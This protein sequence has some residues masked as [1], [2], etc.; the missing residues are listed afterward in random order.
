[1]TYRPAFVNVLHLRN[2]ASNIGVYKRLVIFPVLPGVEATLTGASSGS[3]EVLIQAFSSDALGCIAL[4]A[5]VWQ[6]NLAAKVDSA[7]DITKIKIYVYSR[8]QAGA[9]TALFN[10]LT[11]EINNTTVALITT[12]SAVQTAFTVA[13]TDRLI[14]KLYALSDSG[15]SKTVT[16]YMQGVTNYSTV[17]LPNDIPVPIG[18][19][20]KAIYDTDGDG[21]F[22]LDVLDVQAANTV[23]AGRVD[24]GAALVPTFRGL[25]ALD[26]PALPY[27][28]NTVADANSILYAV[29][30]DVPAAL[31]LAANTFPARSSAG[32]ILAK[33]ITD[34]ALTIL[35]DADA[36]TA[37]ATLGVGV[38]GDISGTGVAGQVAEFVT[39]TKTIQAA[40]IIGPVSNILTITN[41]AASTLALA[42][43]SGKT[44]TLTATDNFNLTVG[45]TLTLNA[46]PIGGLSV[47]TAANTIGSLAVGLTTQILV[48]GGAATVPAWGTDL[49]TAVTIGSAYVYRAAGTDIPV[50]DGG[51]GASALA[52]GGLVIGNA[53]G[54]VSVVAAGLTTQ[55][56][57]G[58]G[59][60]T[61]PAW[62][63]DLPTA[64]T[65]GGGYVF[66]A[67]GT[68]VGVADGGTGASTLADGGLVIGNGA[69][70][71]SVVAAG[72]TTQIL[73]GGGALTD[74]AWG[75]DL[76]TA[77]T[78]GT[79]YVFRVGGTDVGVADGG[80]GVSTL[81]DGGLM[82]GNAA[83]AVSVV[84]AGLTTQILVGG[85]A[86]TDPA[87]GTDL[88]TAVTIGS[89]YI[90][91]VG[92][93]DVN[94]P[95]GGTGVSTLALNGILFGNDASAVG[96]TAIG[97]QYNILTVGA[98]P[99][100]PAWSGYLLDGTTGGKTN[101][102]VTSGKTLT[103]TAV[104]NA[105]LTVSEDVTIDAPAGVGQIQLGAAVHKTISIST[106]AMIISSTAGAITTLFT[107]DHTAKTMAI[108]TKMIKWGITDTKTLT[109]TATDDF[110][111]TIPATGTAALG[112]GTATRLAVWSTANTLAAGTI[113]QPV[114][115]VLTVTNSAA[116]TLALAITSAK[117]LTLTSTDNF[118]LTIP[119]TGT[120]LL[121]EDG[122]WVPA[123]QTWTYA[124]STT[125]T[126]ATNVTATYPA[127]TKLKLTNNSVKYFYVLSATY[128]APN[129]TVTVTGGSDYTVADAAITLPFYSYATTPQG[130]PNVFNFTPVWTGSGTNPVINNGTLSGQFIMIGRQVTYAILI[131]MG[132]TTTYGTG[133]WSFTLP[134]AANVSV[135]LYSGTAKLL[136][137]STAHYG[138]IAHISTANQLQLF[139]AASGGGAMSATV[140][141]TWAV[142]DQLRS[143]ITYFA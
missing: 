35:D 143:T 40:K 7:T 13:V 18:D 60:L 101:L 130:F 25:V 38:G 11:A 133:E 10:V 23:L 108:G 32:N 123:G 112:T 79:A 94:V 9:E 78:I 105:N 72:L 39:D 44:L 90:Y 66:R 92:G 58:G 125:F 65:I 30:N 136:D 89:G 12:L 31:A 86:L 64:V 110:N 47:A 51:T 14:I 57:V 76:P 109:L 70:A 142:N 119:A 91:R 128:G 97:A 6:F 46:Q 132:S 88:P 96:V 50:T 26:I 4:P 24:V 87:W 107:F 29:T 95:N 27:M 52:D 34:F 121:M 100:V 5:G 139:N 75:T 67:G 129:T 61:D 73:V 98:S 135:V 127:G 113:V 68:D 77:V 104:D 138:V 82:V 102:A 21:F 99:F 134:V 63:T 33:T 59:A 118:N 48:G 53:A 111:L 137:S 131:N 74:P 122:G 54:A 117:T 15:S 85:G 36:A 8:N 114:T 80:T 103:L 2:D 56:L 43:T 115:N 28:L 93:T 83:G 141:F 126:I 120:V 16:L 62:G 140:P 69:G 37:R 84:A 19:M 45:S 42:I 22:S 1:M 20:E 81:A 3:A 55:I 49:P 106:T 124:S 71:V 41:S 116:S 17:V